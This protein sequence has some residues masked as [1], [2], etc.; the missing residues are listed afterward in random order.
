MYNDLYMSDFSKIYSEIEIS[1]TSREFIRTDPL[2]YL[3]TRNRQIREAIRADDVEMMQELLPELNS[4][5][6][7]RNVVF[8]WGTLVAEQL[9]LT[10]DINLTQNL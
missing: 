6:G 4:V 10:E 3:A 8:Y 1:A 2:G 9:D 7:Q 5:F